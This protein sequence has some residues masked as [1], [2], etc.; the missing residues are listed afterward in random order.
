MLTVVGAD[1]ERDVSSALTTVLSRLT[2][3]QLFVLDAVISH[4]KSLLDS[5]DQIYTTKLALSIG[6]CIL[7]PQIET[8][9][10]IGD[11]TASLFVADLI[12]HYDAIFSPLIEKKSKESDRIMPL[13]K[14]T[15]LVDQRISRSRLS[16]EQDP[17]L[18]FE[19]QI[20]HREPIPVDSAPVPPDVP[21]TGPAPLD[22]AEESIVSPAGPSDDNATA[23]DNN[24]ENSPTESTTASIL[25]S[26][27]PPTE[28]QPVASGTGLKRNTSAEVSRLRG[29]RGARGPRPAPTRVV[30]TTAPEEPLPTPTERS[31]GVGV[32]GDYAPKRGKGATSA[33]AVRRTFGFPLTV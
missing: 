29:P 20:A 6:R 13:R 26:F 22:A 10:S 17:R 12:T 21:S 14:R 9:L 30:S 31:G 25:D 18:I 32:A 1:L 5:S 15:A 28:D 11:R 7:R 4:F 8:K 3:V 2:G 24:D 19:Q 16:D 23:K 33:G 27:D